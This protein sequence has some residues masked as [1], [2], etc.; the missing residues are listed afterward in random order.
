MHGVLGLLNIGRLA[1]ECE[2]CDYKVN[3]DQSLQKHMQT[4]HGAGDGL[5]GRQAALDFPKYFSFYGIGYC[6]AWS[7]SVVQSG[8]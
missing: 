2:E 4:I 8:R 6:S 3:I 1:G 5:N 7:I